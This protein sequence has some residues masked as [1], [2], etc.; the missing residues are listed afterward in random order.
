MDSPSNSYN[1]KNELLEYI[2]IY[3]YPETN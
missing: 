1:W 2:Y 3:I